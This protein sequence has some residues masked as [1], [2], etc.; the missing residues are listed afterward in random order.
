MRRAKLHTSTSVIISIL[1]GSDDCTVRQTLSC[2]VVGEGALG[3][4]VDATIVGLW[5]YWAGTDA[6]ES[7]GICE[8]IRQVRANWYALV[9]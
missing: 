3:T 7:R 4:G 5:S 2:I 1:S 6:S 9:R 8:S